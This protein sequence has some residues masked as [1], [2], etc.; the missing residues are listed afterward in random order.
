[1]IKDIL[2][3]KRRTITELKDSLMDVNSAYSEL[4][5]KKDR[6]TKKIAEL[7][8]FKKEHEKRRDEFLKRIDSKI[9]DEI[10]GGRFE[11]YKYWLAESFIVD[12]YNR[13]DGVVDSDVFV[14]QVALYKGIDKAVEDI[15]KEVEDEEKG[16]RENT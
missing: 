13:F 6:A 3:E 16:D 15:K 14:D 4:S 2:M 1:M 10:I 11:V 9:P 8:V 7:M 12:K 5:E